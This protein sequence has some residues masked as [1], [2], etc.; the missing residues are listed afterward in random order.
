ML[1]Y[2]LP[3]LI[4]TAFCI[5]LIVIV[6]R[7]HIGSK[8]NRAFAYYLLGL[9]IWGLII[10]AMRSSP[11]L[12]KAYFWERFLLPL[13]PA[14]S[15]VLYRFAHLYSA[16][17]INRWMHITL[18]AICILFI[19]VAFT[20]FGF[21]GMQLKPYGYAPILG[22]AGWFWMVYTYSILIFSLVVFI[23]TY[24]KTSDVNQRNKLLY[25]IIGFSFAL[26]GGLFDLLPLVGLP[27]YPGLIIGNIIFCSFTTIAIIRYNLLDIYIILRKGLAYLLATV[28]FSI[29][30]VTLVLILPGIFMGRFLPV[31]QYVLLVL[32][33]ALLIPPIWRFAQVRV[34]KLFY[35]DRYNYLKEL[36]TFSSTAQSVEMPEEIIQTAVRLISGALHTSEVYL[37]MPAPGSNDMV[38]LQSN[39]ANP[40]AKDIV[41]PA[42][43]ALINWLRRSNSELLCKDIE[44]IPQL[45]AMSSRERENLSRLQAELII[46]LKVRSGELAGFIVLGQKLSEQTYSQEEKQVLHTI[47]LQMATSIENARLYQDALQARKNIEMWLDRMSDCVFIVD[48]NHNIQFRNRA[49]NIK[50]GNVQLETCWGV[51]G[52]GKPCDSCPIK[53]YTNGQ[54][55]NVVQFTVD[56]GDIE[57]DVVT[58]PFI[59]QDGSVSTIEVFRD[60][61]E[62]K[63]AV[64]KL[65]QSEFRY[66]FLVN[67]AAEGISVVQDGIIKFANQK[68]SEITGYSIEELNSMPHD[69]L[70]NSEETNKT[71]SY[72]MP[73]IKTRAF[74]YKQRVRIID[75]KGLTKWLERSIASIIWEDKPASL[76]FDTDI[77]EL[78]K[79]ETE[80]R[81]LEQKA[82]ITNRLASVGEMAAGIAHEINNPLT[83]VIGYAQ[84]VMDDQNIPLNIRKDLTAIYDGS[85][86][87]AGIVQ[88]LLTFARQIKPQKKPVD[89][90]EL[91]KSTLA[92]RAYQL[93]VNN[94]EVTTILDSTLPQTVADPGQ[95]QQ[96]LL[97]LI[98]NAEIEMK[99][100]HGRGKL[101]ITTEEKNNVIRIC[102]IDDGP[103]IKPEIIDRIFDPF[104]TTREV[105]EGTGLGLSLC[106]G[107]VTEH[108]GKIYAESEFGKGATFIVEIPIVAEPKEVAAIT[109]LIEYPEKTF[110]AR[111]LVVDD[112]PV[113]RELANRVLTGEG[114]EVDLADN[115]VD[116]LT[117]IQSHRYSLILLDIKM[118]GMDGI[119]LYERIQNVARSLTRRIIF[120]TGDIMATD[121]EKFLLEAKAA[122]MNKPF[123]GKQLVDEVKRALTALI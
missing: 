21:S 78:N 120:I 2:L 109:P 27:L 89:F 106:Y 85:Q 82:Q 30:F 71:K 77:T 63:R 107:M 92:L 14:I 84:L 80:K 1:T 93:R 119:E 18:W 101:I 47:S 6:L 121:T 91:I 111:I 88:R 70:L 90:N 40:R 113:I 43:S 16:N 15:V 41:F 105:N 4:Q 86:R 33:L 32:L 23:H 112:E 123:T 45:S 13:A 103:G 7:G 28:V 3:P 22:P 67:N 50:F 44:T 79:V 24:R 104:F 74:P 73:G 25:I 58:A 54:K 8:V 94:I 115:A 35:R 37:L 66:R 38:V 98:V 51:I 83:G 81:I 48:N 118:P 31:W 69:K 72:D 117:K 11:D 96:V 110:K 53:L 95:M 17:K 57:Y 87:V 68:L 9:A 20:Q 75:K 29:P 55:I 122:Y 34:D 108:N 49:S 5:A 64:E 65:R 59:N 56:T 114:Y 52:K 12:E 61:T 42:N 76:I 102:V 19:P 39:K 97:N 46:P 62:Y 100:A 36:Q 10:F 99:L 60:I 116:A 26:L